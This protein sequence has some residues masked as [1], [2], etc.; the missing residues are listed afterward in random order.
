M[1]TLHRFVPVN[2]I[3]EALKRPLVFGDK[4]QIAALKNLT[5]TIHQIEVKNKRSLDEL[6]RVYDVTV[7]Y[8]GTD[9]SRIHAKDEF[10]ARSIA[11]DMLTIDV[12]NIAVT[13]SSSKLV[14]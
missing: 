3:P 6:L 2:M 8:C 9:V 5:M 7:H 13:S 10:S 4:E 1:N 12:D 11:L 14:D